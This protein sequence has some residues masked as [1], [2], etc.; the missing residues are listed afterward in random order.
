MAVKRDRTQQRLDQLRAARSTPGSEESIRILRDALKDPSNYVV[1][2]AAEIIEHGLV[3]ETVPALLE[4]FDRFFAA[5]NDR[6]CEA[7]TAIAKALYALDYQVADPYLKGIRHH[8]PEGYGTQTDVATGLRSVCGLALVQTSCD[9]TL[10]ELVLLL[11]DE[12]ATVRQ[13][14]ARALGCTGLADAVV[15]LLLFKV[16]TGDP[17]LEVIAECM[18][19]ML[20]LAPRRTLPFVVEQLDS[21]DSDRAEAAAV[22]LGTL[23]SE[24]AFDALRQKWDATAFGSIRERILHAMAASRT[25]PAIAFLTRLVAE[26]PFKTAVQALRALAIHRRD[27]RIRNLV[28]EAVAKRG[29]ELEAAFSSTFGSGGTL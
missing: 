21:S 29:R 23:R 7:L 27:A 5:Q 10:E 9:R 28:E 16:H 26:E 18:V 13:S 15:P 12:Y 11:T 3:A 17:E 4:A 22:A 20:A 1:A 25:D 6:G 2:K 19:S 8:Q 24:E 14:A